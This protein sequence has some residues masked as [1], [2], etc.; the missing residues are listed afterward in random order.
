MDKSTFMS[1]HHT[2][3][4]EAVEA[5]EM[6]TE[7]SSTKNP[8]YDTCYDAF[9]TDVNRGGNDDDFNIVVLAEIFHADYELGFRN[10]LSVYYNTL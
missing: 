6:C 3:I 4:S 1:H 8:H 2:D 9:E 7:R 10:L 5:L